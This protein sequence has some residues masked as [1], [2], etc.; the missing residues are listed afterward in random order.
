[1]KRQ[2]TTEK[3]FEL[4]AIR[5]SVMAKL[6]RK[7]LLKI[8]SIVIV[9]AA[10]GSAVYP[11]PAHAEPV[12]VAITAEVALVDDRG[13]FLTGAINVGDV[14]TGTYVYES[15]TP[16][17]N[18]LPTVGDYQHTTVPFG[19][20]LNAGGF[21]FRTNPNNVD[22]LVEIVNNHGNPPSDNYLLRS[23][24]NIFDISVPS[25]MINDIAWQLDDPTLAALSSD[26]LPAVPP[27]LADWQS[28]F[29]LTIESLNFFDGN[30]FLVRAHVTSADLCS[31]MTRKKVAICHKPG[32]PAEKT[33]F[34]AQSAAPGHVGHGDA[35]DECP[36]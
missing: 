2:T 7:N 29:G 3:L 35:L 5:T 25:A 8:I 13:G 28:I 6:T 36:K 10:L 27:V 18:P 24:N 22:F 32:T 33:L 26:A 31:D 34:V 20:T 21:V 12:C 14:I 17:T 16:D 1:M 23:S 19:I 30:M 4:A 9:V 15:T 11:A